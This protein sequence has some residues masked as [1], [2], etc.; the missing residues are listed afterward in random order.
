MKITIE[1]SDYKIELIDF[2]NITTNQPLSRSFINRIIDEYIN[3]L[4]FLESF[5][6]G[7]DYGQQNVFNNLSQ[8]DDNKNLKASI[9]EMILKSKCE[10][11]IL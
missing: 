6:I 3:G 8:A 2:K 10:F 5:C 4:R 7:F 9:E 1:E 11:R